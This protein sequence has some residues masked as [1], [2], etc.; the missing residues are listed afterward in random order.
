MWMKKHTHEIERVKATK[1]EKYLKVK[2]KLKLCCHLMQIELLVNAAKQKQNDEKQWKRSQTKKK[3]HMHI[4]TKKERNS[5]YF[6]E[7]ICTS[8]YLFSRIRWQIEC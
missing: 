4:N 6:N 3:K 5:K 7:K 2:I 8:I 1:M